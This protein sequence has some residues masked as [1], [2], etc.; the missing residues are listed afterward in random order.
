MNGK[1]QN[2]AFQL[3]QML[4]VGLLMMQGVLLIVGTSKDFSMPIWI[5]LAVCSVVQLLIVFTYP[6]KIEMTQLVDRSAMVRLRLLAVIPYVL[7]LIGLLA[8]R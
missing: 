6:K 5:G 4:Q 3:T 8:V 2:T 1:K 7:I